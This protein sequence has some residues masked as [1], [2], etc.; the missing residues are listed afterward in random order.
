MKTVMKTVMKKKKVGKGGDHQR[1]F[2]DVL[3]QVSRLTE[4]HGMYNF[5]T[6]TW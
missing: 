1:V 5:M 6:P 4:R 2:L 3:H